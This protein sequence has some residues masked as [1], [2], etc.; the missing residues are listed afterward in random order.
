MQGLTIFAQ[1][2][3]NTYET[4]GNDYST[5]AGFVKAKCAHLNPEGLAKETGQNI[6]KVQLQC[7]EL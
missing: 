2:H 7:L 5:L 4:I 1:L 6:P 3:V